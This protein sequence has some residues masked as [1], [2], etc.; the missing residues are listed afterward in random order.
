[1]AGGYSR[2]ADTKN[3]F[4]MKVD[5]SA[6]KLSS[7]YVNW[8]PLRKRWEAAGYD[9]GPGAIEAGDSIIVPEKVEGKA[10]LREVRD[11]AQIIGNI[12]LTAATVA[13]LY[14]TLKSGSN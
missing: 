13:V 6:R 11:I 5:G 9:G 3:V 14:K 8:N 2:Y 4:V 12:G 7:G 1:M 10:W